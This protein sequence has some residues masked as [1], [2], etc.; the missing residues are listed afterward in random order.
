MDKKIEKVGKPEIGTTPDKKTLY[1]R[2]PNGAAGYEKSTSLFGFEHPI[3]FYQSR[4]RHGMVFVLVS[5]SACEFWQYR[6]T[7]RVDDVG[8]KTG[9]VIKL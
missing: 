9:M 2:I 8:L 5:F 6:V 3:A 7:I 1:V 4:I